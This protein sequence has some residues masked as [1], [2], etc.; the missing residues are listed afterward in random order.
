MH[1]NRALCVALALL[2]ACAFSAAAK[3]DLKSD[4]AHSRLVNASLFSTGDAKNS[5]LEKASR[6]EQT[7][8]PSTPFARLQNSKMKA[9]RR[10]MANPNSSNNGNRNLTTLPPKPILTRPPRSPRPF[11]TLPR[12]RNPPRPPTPPTPPRRSPAPTRRQQD[13]STILNTITNFQNGGN[14]RRLPIPRINK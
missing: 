5:F 14:N 4:R 8:E 3:S 6:N 13:R 11:P 12:N 10:L 1:L 9:A 2:F 7:V